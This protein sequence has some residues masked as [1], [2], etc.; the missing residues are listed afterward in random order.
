MI[1]ISG[2]IWAIF[3]L[4]PMDYS[5]FWLFLFLAIVTGQAKV[6]L[7]AGSS[8]SLITTVVLIAVMMLGTPAGTLVGIYGVFVRSIS[9]SRKF[10]FHQLILIL[11]IIVLTTL[12]TTAASSKVAR[13]VHAMGI[14]RLTGTLV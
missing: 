3:T 6:R 2:L 12:L 8:L 10:V 14:D 11:G 13:D 5:Y 9:P 1:G 4:E 7:I